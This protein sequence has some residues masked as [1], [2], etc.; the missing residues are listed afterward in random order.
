M[1]YTDDEIDKMFDI[2]GDIQSEIYSLACMYSC[3][4]YKII[5]FYSAP[6]DTILAHIVGNKDRE[7]GELIE[8]LV[9]FIDYYKV[10]PDDMREVYSHVERL[11]DALDI[12]VPCTFD[13]LMEKINN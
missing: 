8:K 1:E 13:G 3:Y 4:D 2:V 6:S 11:C 9:E 10:C 5:Y 7:L 12:K